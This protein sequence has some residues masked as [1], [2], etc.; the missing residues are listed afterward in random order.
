MVILHDA[1]KTIQNSVLV[2]VSK[3]RTKTC[4]ISKT[5]KKRIKKTCE[6]FVLKPVYFNPAYLSILFCAFHF[7]AR[8][9]T[10]HVTPSLIGCA[11]HT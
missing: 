8:S 1:I 6:L 11:R 5:Q 10:S 9:R 4:F 7:I 2:H 3:K